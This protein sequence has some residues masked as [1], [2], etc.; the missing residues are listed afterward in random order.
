[1]A[2]VSSPP[3]DYLSFFDQEPLAIGFLSITPNLDE[4]YGVP[5]PGTRWFAVQNY[6]CAATVSWAN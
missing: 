4:V 3:A 6:A 2:I 5:T 1:L